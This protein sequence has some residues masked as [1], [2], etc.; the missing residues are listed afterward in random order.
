MN[1]IDEL[2]KEWCGEEHTTNSGRLVHDS[3]E[4]QD[5]AQF[6]HKRMTESKERYFHVAFV[7][8]KQSFL[9][10]GS[11]NFT[12]NNGKLNHDELSS[13]INKIDNVSD[14]VITFIHE[15]TKEQYEDWTSQTQ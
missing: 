13:Y 12:V 8:R 11:L 15:F 7:G 4:A 10:Y 3:S 9:H 2:Y 1:K 5:F 6:F 14:V